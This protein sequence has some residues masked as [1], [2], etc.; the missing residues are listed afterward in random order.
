MRILAILTA[1]TLVLSG[2][3]APRAKRVEAPEGDAA[4]HDYQRAIRQLESELGQSLQAST[5]PECQRMCQ[6]GDNI[7]DLAR[8]ICGIADR[9]PEWADTGQSCQDAR[10]RCKKAADAVSRRCECNSGHL[11]KGGSP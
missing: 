7:C 6:L 5:Q 11:E 8:K 9:H 4:L 3:A 10:Q 1:C 2:C